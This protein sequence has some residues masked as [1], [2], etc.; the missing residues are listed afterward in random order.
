MKTGIPCYWV[1]KGLLALLLFLVSAFPV[2]GA[3]LSPDDYLGDSAIYAGVPSERPKP[4]ILLIIDTSLATLNPAPGKE[5]KTE[6]TTYNTG[7]YIYDRIYYSDQQGEFS[8]SRSLGGGSPVTWDRVDCVVTDTSTGLISLDVGSVLRSFGTYSGSG[9]TVAPNLNSSGTCATAPNGVVYATGHYLNYVNT[10]STALTVGCDSRTIIIKHGTWPSGLPK[11]Y[12]LIANI[13]DPVNLLLSKSLASQEPGVGTDWEKYWS[14]LT[15]TNPSAITHEINISTRRGVTTVSLVPG[16]TGKDG[17][18]EGLNSVSSTAT[19]TC[20]VDGVAKTQAVATGYYSWDLYYALTAAEPNTQRQAFY[21]ALKPV[22]QGASSGVNF[23]FM[24]YNPNNQGAVVGADILSDAQS[25]DP[26]Q[27][28]ILI[29]KLPSM[30]NCTQNA[31]NPSLWTCPDTI[32]SG[33]NRPQSE[34]LYDAGYYFMKPFGAQY[35]NTDGSAPSKQNINVTTSVPHPN[36]CGYNHIIFLTNGL[37]NQDSGTPNL[38]DWSED[39]RERLNDASSVQYGLGT[40]LLDDVAAYLKNEID[41]RNPPDPTSKGG[42]ITTHV[43]LAFQAEDDLMRKTA[44]AGGGLFYNA[45]GTEQLSKAL[46]DILANIVAETDT[47]FVAPVVPASSTN[48]TRSGKRVYLGLFKPQTDAAWQGNLK[49]YKLG[50]NNELLDVHGHRATLSTDNTSPASV[51]SSCDGL[52]GEFL[53]YSQSFW[54]TAEVGTETKI[55]SAGGPRNVVNAGYS[56]PADTCLK[57]PTAAAS[58]GGDG[59]IVNAGG[60]GGTLLARDVSTRNIFTVA[61]GVKKQLR[62]P[63]AGL[64]PS[65][66]DP[67]VMGFSGDTVFTPDEELKTAQLIDYVYGYD[68]Y[69]VT[70][71]TVGQSVP[72]RSWILGDILH[73]KPLVKAYSK[74]KEAYENQCS[75]TNETDISGNI[76]YT[77]YNK[78]MIYVGAN[79]GMLHAFRDCDG[80]EEWAFV[81]PVLLDKLRYLPIGAHEYFVDGSPVTYTYDADGDGNIATGDSTDSMDKVILVFGLRRGGG[82]AYLTPSDSRGAYYMLDVTDP[83][84]PQYLGPIE[85]GSG[86]GVFSEMGETWSQPMLRWVK[87]YDS[88]AGKNLAVL[89]M[90]VGAGYDNNEDRRWGDTQSFPVSN[91][92]NDGNFDNDTDTTIQTNDG[93]YNGGLGVTQPGSLPDGTVVPVGSQLNPK[94]RGI[95]VIELGRVVQQTIDPPT[96]MFSTANRGSLIRAFTKAAYANMNFSFPTDLAVVD[97]NNDG[98]SDRVYAGDTGGQLWRFDLLDVNSDGKDE[99]SEWSARVFYRANPGVDGTNGRKFFY[100]P[101]VGKDGDAAL[102]YFGSG[103][104]EHPLNRAVKDRLYKVADRGCIE[105]APGCTNT[106]KVEGDLQDKTGL[107]FVEGTTNT[108]TTSCDDWFVKLLGKGEKMLADPVL[109]FDKILY[110]T[111]EADPPALETCK[112]GNLGTARLYILDAKCGGVI[113]IVDLGEG[114]P[115]G[116]VVLVSNEGE[117]SLKAA[118]SGRLASVPGGRLPISIPLYWSETRSGVD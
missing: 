63:Q 79:D 106:P 40:H 45:Y 99:P 33:P 8:A 51:L 22:I 19:F 97:W 109:F 29:D 20:T 76:T 80:G 116:I 34:A 9:S 15:E 54:G 31:T 30:A 16:Y 50:D 60:V 38:G 115:S 57:D 66:L 104:R 44:N 110:T 39:G 103:D 27:V 101:D 86:G 68:S 67:Y 26:A 91:W 4:N 42:G 61:G 32:R 117:V 10:Q 37:P 70:Y 77:N 12:K 65:Y 102:V 43:I 118:A 73:S 64:P 113:S 108:T 11:K 82:N 35:K 46:L 14:L 93:E 74:F 62:I 112:T 89:A 92:S 25:K 84:N 98:F 41:L 3:S 85:Q 69:G 114:I 1:H 18:Y 49:K 78:T 5:Y 56:P 88:V 59:G 24:T 36:L 72:K 107:L 100:R 48:R 87:V 13:V 105:N 23:G 21:R 111:Y 81:P 95:F 7:T 55:M 17:W 2:T 53:T 96:Y 6:D 75:G 94:G 28:G 71:A 58:G 47:A 52:V 90:L 83:S